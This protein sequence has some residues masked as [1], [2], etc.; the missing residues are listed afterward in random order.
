[1]FQALPHLLSSWYEVDNLQENNEQG[2]LRRGQNGTEGLFPQSFPSPSG[3]G[4]Y[5]AK[6]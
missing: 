5:K 6:G 2:H 3:S 4:S 1:M